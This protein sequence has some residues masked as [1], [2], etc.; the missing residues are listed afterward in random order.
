MEIYTF[1]AFVFAVTTL[2]CLGRL[3]RLVRDGDDRRS[4]IKMAHCAAAFFITTV[5]CAYMASVSE[6]LDAPIGVEIP[7]SGVEL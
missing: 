1:M 4:A 2:I 7:E 3:I 5:I 6:P